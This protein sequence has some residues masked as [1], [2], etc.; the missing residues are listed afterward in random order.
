MS[1][2]NVLQKTVSDF[3]PTDNFPRT[4]T[5]FGFIIFTQ[6]RIGMYVDPRR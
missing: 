3:C 4:F 6:E 1:W 5:H 2:R